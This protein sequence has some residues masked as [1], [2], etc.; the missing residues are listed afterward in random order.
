M[1]KLDQ[2]RIGQN[3]SKLNELNFLQPTKEYNEGGQSALS[4]NFALSHQRGGWVGSE[5]GNS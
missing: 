2:I 5:N 1:V 4:L 3:G